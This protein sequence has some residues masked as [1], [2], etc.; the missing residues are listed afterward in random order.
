MIEGIQISI[1]ALPEELEKKYM[2]VYLL[3]E[4]DAKVIC[5]DK[6]TSD[7]FEQIIA[8]YKKL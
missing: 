6:Q 2:Q 3:S 1:P 8:A 5:D 7:F 4:Y